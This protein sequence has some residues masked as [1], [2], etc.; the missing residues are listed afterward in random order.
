[1]ARIVK[2]HAVRRSEILDVAQRLIYTKGYEQMTIQD[3][4]DNLQISKGAFYHYFDS[5]QA[6]LEALIERMKGE[7]EQLLIPIVY[8]PYLPA[9]EKLQR[10]FDTLNRWKTAQKAFFLA[11][12]RVWYTDDNA[13]VRQKWRAA[14]IKWITPLLSVIIHQ[15]I[16]EGVL[17]TSYPDQ[18]GE[19]VL[20][21]V[22]DLGE[23]LAMLLLSFE[24]ERADIRRVESIVAAYT[25]ALERTLGIPEGSLQL[26]DTETLKEWFFSPGDNA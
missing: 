3:M 22:Q 9:L 18:V 2:E 23:T 20:S 10:F 11:L 8:D 12:L 5:K 13:I 24:P 17:T 19:V 7:V 25:D 1:M 4:L 14:G 15:G 21:L 26:T 16:Q 6:L